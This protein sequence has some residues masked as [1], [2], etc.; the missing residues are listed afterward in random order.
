MNNRPGSAPNFTYA[1]IVMFGINIAWILVVIWAIW[2][3]IAAA[4]TGWGVH[5]VIR[6]IDAR[7]N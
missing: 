7:R 4:A 6:F 2:G 1:C 3:L 5:R